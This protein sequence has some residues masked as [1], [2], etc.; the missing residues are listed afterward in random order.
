MLL[1]SNV[2]D[3]LATPVLDA[4]DNEVMSWLEALFNVHF[5]AAREA[6]RSRVAE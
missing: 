3:G 2:H 5:A 1:L 6:L 4:D